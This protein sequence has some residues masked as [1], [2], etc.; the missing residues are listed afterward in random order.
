MKI[1]VAIVDDKLINRNTVKSILLDNLHIEILFEYVSGIDFLEDL[2]N[3]RENI[4]IVLMD[5]EMPEL[6]GI[7]TIKR[8]RI[9]MPHIKFIVLTVFEDSDKIFEAIKAGAHGYLLK[10]DRAIDTIEA[11]KSVYEYGAV[12][13]SPIVAR[14]VLAF[15]SAN[16]VNNNEPLNENPLS[17]REMDVLNLL[18]SGKR[19]KK[20]GDLL[21]ISPFTVRRHVNNIYD[22]LHVKSRSEVIT[23]VYK[24]KWV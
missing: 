21:F 20:I 1:R 7:E 11:I 12:P 22:K 14:K 16:P 18:V 13:M 3:T 2:K 5:V 6:S 4:D 15:M 19:Y 24:Q 23:L 17:K 8:A 10:E 9:S